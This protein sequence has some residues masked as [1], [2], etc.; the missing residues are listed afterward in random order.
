M[1][2]L[3][4]TFLLAAIP[5]VLLGAILAPFPSGAL[6]ALDDPEVLNA[7]PY[8]LS[9]YET[10]AARR[11]VVLMLHGGG[12]HGDLGASADEVMSEWIERFRSWGYDIA[13]LAYRSGAD[14][15]TDSLAAFDLL[16]ARH[17][18]E[19]ICLFGGS[20]GGHLALVVAERRGASVDCVIDLLGPTNLEEWGSRPASDRGRELAIE[21]FGEDRL[22][23]LSPINHVDEIDSSVL[24]VAAP[25]DV[26]LE[27]GPQREFVDALN[28][29]GGDGTL[30]IV[31][32]GDDVPLG[33]CNVDAASF[34]ELNDEMRSFLDSAATAPP[35]I[36]PDESDG[37]GL[38]SFEIIA[39]VVLAAGA[40]LVVWALRR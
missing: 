37:S 22:A 17:P 36:D 18:D 14:S 11:G 31:Q 33:H 34:A 24:V 40:G 20:A 39:A 32:P 3:L 13:N 26:F 6:G 2:P 23:E 12:W 28:A 16:R 38:G 1:K 15:L 19:P 29:A 27:V 30:Q 5:W 25:C 7:D 35:Q 4:R 21:A 9:L 8:Y 10:D